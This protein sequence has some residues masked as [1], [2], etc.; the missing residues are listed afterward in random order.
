MDSLEQYVIIKVMMHNDKVN[1]LY[2]KVI[3][4]DCYKYLCAK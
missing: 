3:I 1:V 2:D 4:H